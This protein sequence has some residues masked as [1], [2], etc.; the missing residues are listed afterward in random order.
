MGKV[1]RQRITDNH[2]HVGTVGVPVADGVTSG[3]LDALRAAIAGIN[4]GTQGDSYV[5]DRADHVSGSDAKAVDADAIKF[6]VYV[7]RVQEATYG[8][9]IR[10]S[11]PC[12]D[13]SLT[14]G[15]VDLDLAAGAG[16]AMKSAVEA[17]FLSEYGSTGTVLSITFESA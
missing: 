7:V 16:L 15:S 3:Q 17:A 5:T 13:N 9:T 1:Y 4:I 10:F 11:I 14:G 6:A 8:K 12:A 2:G